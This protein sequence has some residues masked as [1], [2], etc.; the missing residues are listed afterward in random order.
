[1]YNSAAVRE[2]FD[3]PHYAMV[4]TLFSLA[5]AYLYAQVRGWHS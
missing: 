2:P 3:E 4:D 5:E 1:M